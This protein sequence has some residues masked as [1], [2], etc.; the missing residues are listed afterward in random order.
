MVTEVN[1]TGDS[2]NRRRVHKR[3]KVGIAAAA[4]SIRLL[5]NAAAKQGA[6]HS[7]SQQLSVYYSISTTSRIE[8]PF[9]TP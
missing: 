7:T 9:K 2:F 4:K 5:H 6:I 8:S 1:L 3:T